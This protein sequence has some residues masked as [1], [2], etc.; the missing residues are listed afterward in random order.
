MGIS[1]HAEGQTKLVGQASGKIEQ[2]TEATSVAPVFAHGEGRVVFARNFDV[3]A[4]INAGASRTIAIGAAI[5]VSGRIAAL[6]RN[7][8]D[9][10][11]AS[12]GRVQAD[13]SNSIA[14]P[15]TGQS[16]GQSQHQIIAAPHVAISA[17]LKGTA[18]LLGAATNP[19][20][21]PS[22]AT[23][24][25][26]TIAKSTSGVLDMTGTAD[27]GTG[28]LAIARGQLRL[29][30]HSL[31]RTRIDAGTVPAINMLLRS[32]ADTSQKAQVHAK[33]PLM[34]VAHLATICSA[35]GGSRFDLHGAARTT[36]HIGPA[37]VSDFALSGAA[38]AC[39]RVDATVL[40]G[41]IVTRTSTADLAVVGLAARRIALAVQSDA[42]VATDVR[43]HSGV[44]IRLHATA[45]AG[46]NLRLTATPMR[47]D[48]VART[49][50]AANA[51]IRNG[52]WPLTII[53]QGV[54]APPGLRRSAF[55]GGSQGGAVITQQR[56]GT[57]LCEPRAGRILKG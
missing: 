27:A 51:G 43:A 53:A 35:A 25:T 23:I 6:A 31:T 21:L 32:V 49:F 22:L 56:S 46:I 8:V 50:V 42:W 24:N 41:M 26:H 11:G 9:L 4:D 37:A 12:Q 20:T 18:A 13:G 48:G 10:S 38:S 34:G 28:L 40:N 1:G 5:S 54:R 17:A 33:L 30:R 52:R 55:P 29:T 14:V 57:L 19:L 15:F 45:V 7:A 44:A 47:A 3:M 39:S 2:K 16:H 36:G